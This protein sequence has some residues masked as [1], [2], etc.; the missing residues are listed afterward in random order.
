MTEPIHTTREIEALIPHRWPFL[1]VDR[2]VEYDPERSRIVGQQGRDRHRVVLPGPLPG[3]CR[4]CPACCRWRRSPRPWPSTWR[5]SRAS[6]TRSGSSPASTSAASSGSS[7][8]G[9]DLR[10][11]ITMEKLGRRFG[12]GRG[13]ASVD[14][15]VAC[16]AL[17]AFIIPPPGRCADA[18]GI[19]A[20]SP[21]S[22]ATSLALD[23]VLADVRR[24]APDVVAVAGD[25]VV[26]GPRSGRGRGPA[27]ASWRRRAPPSSRATRTSRSRTST[28][29]RRSRGSTTASRS[30]TGRPPSG[31]TSSSA[32]SA[33]LAAP[34]AGRAALPG[35]RRHA[36]ARLPRLAGEPDR[37]ASA[38]AW[39]RATIVERLARTDA[40]VIAAATRTSRRCA[41][42]AGR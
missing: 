12:R 11:E 27:S 21:T 3:P 2:I 15:E 31:R 10:L 16:E 42:W 23:A 18:H 29:R 33:R 26:N 39:T 28:R 24:A 32:P 30:R 37:R 8:P 38:R 19:A 6:A 1:L 14:G 9:D 35:R 41:T 25:Y 20:L 7:I 17:L 36:R 34:A 5:S 40:R 13:V 22:T 4:S